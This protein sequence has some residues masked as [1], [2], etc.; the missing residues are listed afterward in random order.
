MCGHPLCRLCVP[1]DLLAGRGSQGT[2][3]WS[4]PGRLAGTELGVCWGG[5][6]AL[7]IDGAL[8]GQPKLKCMQ[9]R[10]SQGCP[11]GGHPGRTAEVCLSWGIWGPSS[12]GC[13]SGVARAEVGSGLGSP[14]VL[15][16]G[17]ALVTAKS[18]ADMDSRFMEALSA[19]SPLL[20]PK[21]GICQDVLECSNMHRSRV[22]LV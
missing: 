19:E 3:C 2:L 11:C 10:G 9:P 8:T 21:M 5:P 4:F 18:E 6:G 14:G 15:P 22:T 12:R 20:G 17:G 7:R 16:T 1:G 13:P